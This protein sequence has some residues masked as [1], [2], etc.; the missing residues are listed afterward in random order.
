MEL[1][2]SPT[3]G[4]TLRCILRGHTGPINRIAWSPDGRLLASP[5]QDSTIRIW[6]VE[7]GECLFV[8]KG[9]KG[10]VHSVAWSP[11]G[12]IL[13]SGGDGDNP[14]LIWDMQTGSLIR[15]LKYHSQ[16]VLT[17]AWSPD[18][19]TVATGG[20]GDHKIR[21]WDASCWEMRQEFSYSDA[22]VFVLSWSPDGRVLASSLVANGP[23]HLW[24]MQTGTVFQTLTG[25]S[26]GVYD[27]SWL[28]DGKRLASAAHDYTVRVWT[29]EN[30][31]EEVV[32]E[33]S[34]QMVTSVS[35]SADGR[36]LA[37]K[38]EDGA[39][40]IWRTD[41][42][43]RLVKMRETSSPNDWASGID[44]HP[45]LPCL[46]TLGKED[47]LIRI[48]DLD[49]AI[50]LGNESITESVH[51]T[52]AK[53][54]LVGDSGVGK[55]GLGWRLAHGEFKEHPST[56]GQQFWVV[57]ELHNTRKDGTE[58]EAVLW[59]LAGQPVYRPVHAIFLD[60]VDLSL[61]LF[62]PTNRSEPLKGAEFWLEQLAGKKQLPPSV[63][64]GARTDRGTA[65]LSQEE[66][67][68]FC[69]RRGISGGYVGTS[70][71][72]GEGLGELLEIIK[73][74]IPWE[75]MTTTVTTVTFKRIKEYVLELKE[76]PD[77]KGVLVRPEELRIQ[78]EATDAEWEFNDAEM[79][80]AVKHLG[81]HGYVSVLRSS[82]GGEFILLTPEL[83]VDLASS[84]V[85]QADKHPRD[86]GALSE[87]EL[88]K[89]GYPFAEL[90][91][92]EQGEQQILL[93][94]AVDRFLSHSICFRE[95]LGTDALLIFPGL[96]K[97][98][99]PLFD[100]V[101]TTDD[102]SYVVRGRVE[103]VY[104]ALV[105]LLGY[106]QTFTRVNQ[107]Q[108]Q[109]QYQLGEGQI[110]GF[111]LIEEREGEIELV[112]YYSAAMPTFGR[113][114]FQGLF[115][116]FLYQR[117]VD[118]RR[119]PPVVCACG[120]LQQ[121][122][123]VL[124]RIR[125]GKEFL[126]CEE[127]GKRIPLP[128]IE[129]SQALG[130][131]VGRRVRRA[132]ALARLRN[133][134]ETH[135]V[136]VKGF[137]RDRTP[138]RCYVSH[139]PEQSAWASQLARDL[140]DAGAYVIED[141]TQVGE[142]DFILL[143]GTPSY[144]EA[145]GSATG[146]IAADAEIMRPRLRQAKASWPTLIPL[147]LEGEPGAALPRELRG[148]QPGN[149]RD[150][151]R[152]AVALFDLVLTLYTI[153]LDHPAFVPLRESLSRQWEQTLSE[154]AQG[155]REVFIS[156]AWGGESE[157]VAE[158]LEQSFSAE[159]IKVVRDKHDL[160]FKSDISLFMEEIGR[161]ACV[162]LVIS[163]RYLKSANCLFEL[164]QIS[165]HG[166]FAERI[167]PV[168]LGDARIYDPR[169][170][171][172]YVEY[173]EQRRDELDAAMKKVS[174]ASLQGFREDIDLYAEIRDLLPELTNVLKNMNTLT[175]DAQRASGFKE[176][177]EAVMDRLSG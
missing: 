147:L 102:V 2:G 88:L 122:A 112:L 4:L 129:K 60:D 12:Q 106:T 116:Q 94:A 34:T 41:T 152:H 101:E 114:M 174:A 21:L 165:K 30:G 110:C 85:L 144:R 148:C 73:A 24:D 69:Q 168:V 49:T 149:F 61:V 46:A 162:I 9:H 87:T 43:S 26:N 19:M 39:V 11:D 7:R 15:T 72:T 18:G 153:P 93:D 35:F 37:S 154:F 36:L 143:V 16:Y 115:E 108:S 141:R 82:S 40:R 80:T 172:G 5:S 104:A 119:L 62:D 47:T 169:A 1:G 89:G 81:T 170:R 17:V 57:D 121:R 28:P 91:T 130:A 177:F 75:Q 109:A 58:C 32:L 38:S 142:G 67:K 98:K 71:A 156:Y 31:Q 167:F 126:S 83:L 50:L 76:K 145:W 113:T 128:E 125:E 173:W 132:E 135:L 54:V 78:L 163:D 134:Y 95:T 175:A 48:W 136:R 23:I 59:D 29:L 45:H 157:Q 171:L 20:G 68:Q 176:L 66:L 124:K 74:Q 79:M 139:L 138:P 65:V 84:I 166:E 33:D 160:G 99:R 42:W 133:A 13:V 164:V 10:R 161:G 63:L 77:R 70:A 51:Y 27:V 158:E 64:V 120:Q 118:V 107:W 131:Q 8:L 96:I 140:R 127:C 100:E 151:T 55:T 22:N 53:L 103:N 111:R 6:D 92:L 137:R 56:H 52:T 3:P 86:L 25:H 14:V 155:G 146:A 150:A 90:A 44:F 97:Q 117:D 159:D 105:V 123:T